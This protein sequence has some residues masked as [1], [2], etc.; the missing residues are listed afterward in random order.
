M[1]PGLQALL[2][3]KKGT[4]HGTDLDAEFLSLGRP[5]NISWTS[6]FAYVLVLSL[7]RYSLGVYILL[8]LPIAYPV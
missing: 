4:Q 5:R 7:E 6:N 3:L 1:H 8:S 2:D